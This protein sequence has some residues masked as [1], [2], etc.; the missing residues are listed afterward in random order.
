MP[1]CIRSPF[2]HG[3]SELPTLISEQLALIVVDMQYFDA[4][5][6][7]GEGL[8]ASRLGVQAA[9]DEYFDQ[10]KSVVPHIQSLLSVCRDKGVEV[11]HLRVAELTD[12][13]RD[14][15][16]KG[17][18]R[19]LAVPR[20]SKEADLLVE[21]QS[22]GDEI[23]ISKS[24]SGAF[25]ITNLDRILRNM[26][27]HTL[28]FVGTSTGGCVEST[29]CDALDLGYSV[30]LASDACACSTRKSHQIA[31]ERMASGFAHVLTTSQISHLLAD[32]PP[33]DRTSRS[34]VLRAEGCVPTAASRELR[35][36]NPYDFIFGPAIEIP[37][38]PVAA[39]IVVVDAQNM[40]CDPTCGLGK[41]T[42]TSSQR[43]RA[44]YD[45]VRQAIPNIQKLLTAAREANVL[46]TFVRTI[47]QTT[48]G[49]DLSPTVRGLGVV[50]LL[51]SRDAEIVADLAPKH[52]EPVLNKLGTGIFAG[53]GLDELL[54]N[55]GVSTVILVGVSYNGAIEASIR[56]LTDRGYGVVVVP[57]GCATFDERLQK[58]LW[59][60]A[61]GII[62]VASTADIVERVLGAY[63]VHVTGARIE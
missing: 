41:L 61:T 27:I 51:G 28:V 58:L 24:G 22:V 50:P 7:W 57:D 1:E 44:Y 48:D 13:S 59:G 20:H 29:V 25:G 30:I 3:A 21:V 52:G 19:G 55:A 62:N 63:P 5:P 39:A 49:R 16:W 11:I 35:A 12:D 8:T 6:D 34:G 42:D 40:A 31:L 54:R 45:R 17:V 10:L 38:A 32:L 43:S 9:F 23:V 4:H 53:S 15:S 33:V 47:A 26:D 36:E 37:I 60:A 2:R 46:V 56:S 18:V 14:A